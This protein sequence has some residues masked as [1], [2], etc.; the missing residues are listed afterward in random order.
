MVRE[1]AEGWLI[2]ADNLDRRLAALEA[3]RPD[4]D[5]Q[6]TR[7]FLAKLTEEVLNTL[8]DIAERREGSRHRTY[9]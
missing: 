4:V 9:A 5:R 8:H 6:E 3:K 7:A 1:Y 2:K